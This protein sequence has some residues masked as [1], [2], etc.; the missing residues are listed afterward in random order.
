LSE[1]EHANIFV[2]VIIP[3]TIFNEGPK[4]SNQ[5]LSSVFDKILFSLNSF[6]IVVASIS[7]IKSANV[8]LSINLV[9]MKDDDHAFVNWFFIFV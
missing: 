8:I 5:V 4:L 9:A 6:L 3:L 7:R 1:S 2:I